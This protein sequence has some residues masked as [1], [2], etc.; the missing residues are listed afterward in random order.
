VSFQVVS[1]RKIK[2]L[3]VAVESSGE[4]GFLSRPSS[5]EQAMN[6]HSNN[7]IGV[8]FFMFFRFGDAKIAHSCE[9][10]KKF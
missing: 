7:R 2:P 5:L 3:S 6:A 4:E 9:C 10:T 8:I 1:A